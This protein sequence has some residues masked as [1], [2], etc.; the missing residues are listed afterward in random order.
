MR[1]QV[2]CELKY[3]QLRPLIQETKEDLEMGVLAIAA[4]RGDSRSITVFPRF[5]A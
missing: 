5:L 3:V 2:R 4:G 1:F